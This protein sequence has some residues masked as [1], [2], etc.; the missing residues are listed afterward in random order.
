M[1]IQTSP[2]ADTLGYEEIEIE[3]IV[4]DDFDEYKRKRATARTIWVLLQVVILA[5]YLLELS[6][7]YMKGWMIKDPP[8]ANESET[9]Y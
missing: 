7:G 4:L 2:S 9:E 3:D 1:S 6:E 8:Y 5:N